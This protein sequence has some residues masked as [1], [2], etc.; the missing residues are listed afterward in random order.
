MRKHTCTDCH[1]TI[2]SGLAVIRTRSFQRVTYCR[3]CAV[4]LGIFVPASVVEMARAS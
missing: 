1:T 3:P 4:E 2:P